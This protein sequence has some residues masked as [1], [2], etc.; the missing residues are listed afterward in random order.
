MG[1]NLREAGLL[2]PAAAQRTLAVVDEYAREIEARGASRCAIATSAMR[3]ASDGEAFAR[4]VER[5]LSTKLV[6]LS[7]EREAELSFRGATAN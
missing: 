5:R 2:D 7:G 3:R 4:D 1:A 6:I